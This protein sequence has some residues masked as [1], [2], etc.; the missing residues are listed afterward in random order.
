MGTVLLIVLV[1]IN[2][3]P[4][5]DFKVFQSFKECQEFKAQA[6]EQLKEIGLPD[7]LY[8]ECVSDKGEKVSVNRETTKRQLRA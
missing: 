7:P 1:I 4:A 5:F 8:F 2:G 6:V 3:L